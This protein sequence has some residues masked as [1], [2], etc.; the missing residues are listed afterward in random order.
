MLAAVKKSAQKTV[1]TVTS[2]YRVPEKGMDR[3][4]VLAMSSCLPLIANRQYEYKYH[5]VCPFHVVAP[6]LFKAYFPESSFPWLKDVT[7]DN[8]IVTA[9]FRDMEGN[10]TNRIGVNN[11]L[12]AHNYRDLCC[13]HLHKEREALLSL[14][15]YG[16]NPKEE[17]EE[18]LPKTEVPEEDQLPSSLEEMDKFIAKATSDSK[19]IS[20]LDRPVEVVDKETLDPISE[21]PLRR[22]RE[23]DK[24]Y[25]T[26]IGCEIDEVTPQRGEPVLLVGHRREIYVGKDGRDKSLMIPHTIEGRVLKSSEGRSMLMTNEDVPMGMLGG[27]V[28]DVN[29]VCKGMIEGVVQKPGSTVNG[30]IV[31]NTHAQNIYENCTAIIDASVLSDFVGNVELGLLDDMQDEVKKMRSEVGEETI[32]EEQ[33]KR[34]KPMVEALKEENS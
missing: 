24:P 13:F 27:G 21:S 8:V 15:L 12:I 1:M 26:V 2:W 17:R 23:E 30:H 18:V 4:E 20:F 28:F 3:F 16:M 31:H 10:I 5:F 29:G 25:N 11:R 14:K 7:E 19:R 22:L 6:Y 9:E 32:K 34:L 33:Q